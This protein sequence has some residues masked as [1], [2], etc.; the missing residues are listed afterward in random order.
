MKGGMS[1]NEGGASNLAKIITLKAVKGFNDNITSLLS[2]KLSD[3]LT[4]RFEETICNVNT[5]IAK[6]IKK[7]VYPTQRGQIPFADSKI[8]NGRKAIRAMFDLKSLSEMVY[9]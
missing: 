4:E 6:I 1:W 9:R 3:R 5:S 7:D 2:G 8:T